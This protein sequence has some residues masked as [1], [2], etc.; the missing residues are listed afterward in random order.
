MNIERTTAYL[1]T[2]WTTA[3]RV[4]MMIW[5][6]VVEIITTGMPYNKRDAVIGLPLLR[7]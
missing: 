4:L 5:L 7:Q 2:N 1:P 6:T 3:I